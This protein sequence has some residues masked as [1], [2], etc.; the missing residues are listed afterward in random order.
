MNDIIEKLLQE[1]VE[2][3]AKHNLD[4]T[5]KFK[6]MS[7]KQWKMSNE[8]FNKHSSFHNNVA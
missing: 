4:D 5:K 7:K 8:N 1:F 6:Q 3:D 2:S